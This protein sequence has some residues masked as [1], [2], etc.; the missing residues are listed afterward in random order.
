MSSGK[1][2]IERRWIA[3][4]AVIGV[5]GLVGTAV[6]VGLNPYRGMISYVFGFTFWWTLS[7]GALLSLL[8]FHATSARWLAP[9]R[10]FNELLAISILL[11]VIFAVPLI[12]FMRV[13]YPW[14][15]PDWV[16]RSREVIE[17]FRGWYLQPLFYVLRTIGYL[18]SFVALGVI[19]LRL[20]LRQDRELSEPLQKRMRII[21]AST[22]PI[23][24]FTST[25]AC[26]D[27][28]MSLDPNWWSELF[29]VYVLNGG[30]LAA[31][32]LL[33]IIGRRA[34]EI[35]VL[36]TVTREW[37][38]HSL[39]KLLFALVCFW[40]YIA[41]DQYMLIWI[42]N[43]PLEAKWYLLRTE[44]GWRPVFLAIAAAQFLIPFFA[45][46][47]RP[48]K[49]HLRFLTGVCWWLIVAHLC[50]VFWVVIPF[51]GERVPRWTDLSALL[52]IGGIFVAFTL[53]RF[54]VTPQVATGAPVLLPEAHPA[55]S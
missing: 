45:L 14:A 28:L 44:L 23:L 9:F 7:I 38:F 43:K 32:A 17:T 41:Y 42:A 25:F 11:T 22:L 29:G 19:L 46:L 47:S 8:I 20:S 55:R 49:V 52:G 18:V 21:A 39:G 50:D 51:S 27:W 37:H 54:A 13:L 24:L 53:W 33:I 30:V 34:Y 31:F 36:P 40:G 4:S 26:F 15:R 2:V 10:R 12:A 6:G 48:A 5:L 16:D 35:G 3:W 1:L